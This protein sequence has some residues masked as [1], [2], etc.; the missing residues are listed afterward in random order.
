MRDK[1]LLLAFIEQNE[2]NPKNKILTTLKL[3]GYKMRENVNVLQ[4]FLKPK[5]PPM[6][7]KNCKKLFK[8][9]HSF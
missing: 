2:I 7:L 4:K 8:I 9:S 1:K 5:T 3:F 6:N